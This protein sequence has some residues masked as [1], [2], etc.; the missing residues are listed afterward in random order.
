[1]RK[2]FLTITAWLEISIFS[3]SIL[4]A[5]EGSWFH[6]APH[7][8]VQ[9]MEQVGND[10]W[11]N[12]V[13]GI[14]KYNMVSNEKTFFD[15][16][17]PLTLSEEIHGMAR[18]GDGGVIIVVTYDLGVLRIEGDNWQYFDHENSIIPKYDV[19]AISPEKDHKK[20]WMAAQSEPSLFSFDDER[21]VLHEIPPYEEEIPDSTHTIIVDDINRIWVGTDKR[22]LR[23]D[24]GN[25]EW[26]DLSSF[27]K[28][29]GIV[30]VNINHFYQDSRKNLWVGISGNLVKFDGNAFQVIAQNLGKLKIS[31]DG[32]GVIWL[33]SHQEQV[34]HKVLKY[35]HDQLMPVTKANSDIPTESIGAFFR[36]DK[37]NLWM[38]GFPGNLIKYDPDTTEQYT[39]VDLSNSELKL[40][41]AQDM[42]TDLDQNIW[43]MHEDQ[44][45]VHETQSWS[46]IPLPTDLG[47]K[48][49]VRDRNHLWIIDTTVNEPQIAF[50]D[51]GSW[52][53]LTTED[54][55]QAETQL[56][57][58]DMAKNGHIWVLGE[59][60][61]YHHVEG[62][63]N[64]FPIGEDVIPNG[65]LK[66]MTL[67]SSGKLWF[68][69]EYASHLYSFDGGNLH[70]FVHPEP[71][72][73]NQQRLLLHAD[74]EDQIW[75]YSLAGLFRFDGNGFF[76]LEIS[77]PLREMFSDEEGIIFVSKNSLRFYNG[78]EWDAV[79]PYNSSLR[80]GKLGKIVTDIYGN[81]W[82]S[83]LD[84]IRGG[85]SI[86]NPDGIST[87]ITSISPPL[88]ETQ[89]Q[90][91]SYPNPFHSIINF[92]YKLSHSAHVQMDIINIQGKI[93]KTIFSGKQTIGKHTHTW[94]PNHLP[95]QLFIARLRI[96]NQ[97][98]SRMIMVDGR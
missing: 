91:N 14:V 29:L 7:D 5:Q 48:I 74:Q 39:Q 93:V 87:T 70:A 51:N 35:Q 79:D 83:N 47:Q 71:T 19:I 55:F 54:F 88:K 66:A 92:E 50:L 1:M 64:V 16:T 21:W 22:L 30:E 15:K 95:A 41:E 36:D 17:H 78:L 98:T 77:F 86:Y 94:Q 57:D 42:T 75:M 96:N 4:M 56:I 34:S 65:R 61:I 20:V 59:Q 43:I 90:F 63:W 10:L 25:E 13:D 8:R 40:R 52:Q 33:A 72:G 68:I 89:F 26:A 49:S 60:A 73:A 85:I 97:M 23:F 28:E 67:D 58:I 11:I 6:F 31:E 69:N 53:F 46:E 9:H 38:G 18:L 24:Q 80:R 81:Y 45:F 44:L 32:A 27:I 37:G 3:L 76:P 12:T 2:E 62:E 82:I 84:S